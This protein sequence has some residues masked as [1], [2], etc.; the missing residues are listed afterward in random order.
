MPIEDPDLEEP[1]ELGP[2]V[3]CFLRGSPKNSEE[4][5]APSPKPPVKE[6]C[7]WVTWRAEACDTPGWW[8]ELLA[9]PEVQDCNELAWKVQASFHLP[10]RVSKLKKME[11]YHQ[12][13]PAPPCLLKKNFLPPPNSIFTCQDIREVQREKMVA[14]T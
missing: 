3:T 10:K 9:V 6:L 11:N 12:A 5:K 4:E 2:E 13:P 1:L 7:R 14:Y 8:R